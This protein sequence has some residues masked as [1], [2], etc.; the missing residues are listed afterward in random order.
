MILDGPHSVTRTGLVPRTDHVTDT[1]T[2]T[3]TTTHIATPTTL[4]PTILELTT[5]HRITVAPTTNT[6]DQRTRGAQITTPDHTRK[7][8]TEAE[9]TITEVALGITRLTV[10]TTRTEIGTAI[11]RRRDMEIRRA[12]LS[13]ALLHRR[14]KDTGKTNEA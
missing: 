14:A 11:R 13:L 7:V 6:R 2:A 8:G 10:G 4:P 3:D 5:D 9:T 12:L 1:I